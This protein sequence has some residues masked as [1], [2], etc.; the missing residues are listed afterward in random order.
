M[1]SSNYPV[2]AGAL[3]VSV[4]ARSGGSGS[5]EAPYAS[6]QSAVDRAASGATLV[7][8]GGTYHE[9]VVIPSGK[10][11]TIQSYPGEAVWF[12]GSSALNNWQSTGG[13]WFSA[14]WKYDFDATPSFTRGEADGTAA[15]WRWLNAA[16]PMAAHPE[17]VWIDG[18]AQAEVSSLAALKAGTFFT[19]VANDRLYLGSDPTGHSVRTSTLT[20]ALSLRGEGAVVRGVGVRN[21]ATSVWMMGAVTVE[22]PRATLENVVIYD[23]ASTGLF[24]GSSNATIRDVTLARNG[25]MGLGANYADALVIDDLLAVE[26][27]A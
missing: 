11:L 20:K 14:D 18:V 25:L 16:H 2:P 23:N 8:R 22:A 27:N 15:G 17:Q 5:A 10:K 3:F 19:D 7:L 4:G 1:G 21:Y 26:N 6:V 9:S 12:D 13:R 24:V